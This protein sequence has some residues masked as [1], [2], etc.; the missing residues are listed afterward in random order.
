MNRKKGGRSHKGAPKLKVRT[1]SCSAK[2]GNDV[3]VSF[4]GYKV[5]K[6]KAPIVVRPVVSK[7]GKNYIEMAHLSDF[8]PEAFNVPASAKRYEVSPRVLRIAN[9]MKKVPIAS[10]RR[11]GDDLTDI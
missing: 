8:E 7:I 6:I 10:I 3:V 2:K 1:F 11:I 9:L 5:H 4:E